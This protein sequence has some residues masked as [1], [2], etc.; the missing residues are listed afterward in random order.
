MT[1]IRADVYHR[2]A[3]GDIFVGE[4]HLERLPRRGQPFTFTRRWRVISVWI[5]KGY[6]ATILVKP[7]ED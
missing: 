1:I 4:V 7:M 3:N 5:G 2:T 6:K